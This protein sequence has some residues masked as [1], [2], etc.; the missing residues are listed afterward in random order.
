MLALDAPEARE[1]RC[2]ERQHSPPRDEEP[3][4]PECA[5]AAQ[6]FSDGD[7]EH[8]ATDSG[9]EDTRSNAHTKPGSITVRIKARSPGRSIRCPMIRASCISRARLTDRAPAPPLDLGLESGQI[10]LRAIIPG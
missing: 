8:A 1:H 2:G 4:E 10:D 5:Q 6:Q 9:S 3:G 7:H